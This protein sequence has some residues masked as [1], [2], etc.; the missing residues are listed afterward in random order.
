MEFTCLSEGK[1]F[2]YP[3]CHI[4][5]ISGFRILLDCPM[6]LSSL[7]VFSPVPIDPNPIISNEKTSLK[8]DKPLDASS[9]I[10]AQ[11]RYRTVKN[12]ILWDVSFIDVVL[13]SSP[14]GMMGLPFLTRNKDF[15]A[16]VYATEVAARIGQLMMEDLVAMHKEYRQFYGPEY[17]S[18]EWMKWDE[19]DSLPIELKQILFGADGAGFAGWMPLYSAA[20]VKDCMLKVESLKYAEET[21]YNG[22]LMMSAFSSGLEIGSCNWKITCP[23][24]SVAYISSSVFSPLT[25]MSFDYKSLQRSDVILYSDFSSCNAAD[26]F[27]ADNNVSNSSD[28][29][30]NLEASIKLGSVD[31]YTEEMEKLNF[32]CSSSIDFIK[33]GGSVLI[34]IGRHGIVLQLLE[35]L[36]VALENENM[37]KSLR[38]MQISSRNGYVSSCKIVSTL[39]SH[40]L[41][42]RRC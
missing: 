30:V 26:N 33:A 22:T 25:A 36:A 27:E 13:I 16:K 21:C 10:C 6:D 41:R 20:D 19:L 3:P 37:K 11:P 29:D 34:P 38:H 9:L 14:M 35:Q 8:I 23:K 42:T 39:V 28:D 18:P 24:G 12:L 7:L 31:E 4:L 2:Y 1:G 32:I 17:D 15:S 40:Y 5:D